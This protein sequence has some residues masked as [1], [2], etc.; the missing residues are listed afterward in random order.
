M[1][2]SFLPSVY[3]PCP[4]EEEIWLDFSVSLISP[5]WNYK[6]YIYNDKNTINFCVLNH[7]LSC[8]HLLRFLPL[9][10]SLVVQ[11]HYPTLSPFLGQAEGAPRPQKPFLPPLSHIWIDTSWTIKAVWDRRVSITNP[12]SKGLL[13]AGGSW[14]LIFACCLVNSQHL[15]A[16][17]HGDDSKYSNFIWID[18]I[19]SK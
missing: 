7:E 11:T 8:E 19:A 3:F 1:P 2:S 13:M 9:A 10:P 4:R 14:N 16:Q 12:K 18:S 17:Q 6:K 5:C 15:K